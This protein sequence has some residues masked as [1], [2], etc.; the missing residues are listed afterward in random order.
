[1]NA[2]EGWLVLTD[3]AHNLLAW[4]RPWMLVGSSFETFGP[5][6]LVHDLLTIPGHITFEE[7]RLW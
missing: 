7:G 4:L 3:T 5:K 6:R 2:Q 1:L